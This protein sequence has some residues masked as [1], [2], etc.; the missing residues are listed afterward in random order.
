MTKS[1]AIDPAMAFAGS[2]AGSRAGFGA[3][4]GA[5]S[6]IGEGLLK[7][8]AITQRFSADPP[9]PNQPPAQASV[10]TPASGPVPAPGRRTMTA[11]YLA[12]RKVL[13]EGG[14][15]SE[16]AVERHAA[17]LVAT[18]PRTEP[19]VRAAQIRAQAQLIREGIPWQEN[20]GS[21]FQ[22]PL[23]AF[24]VASGAGTGDLVAWRD[25]AEAAF[26]AAGITTSDPYT[27]VSAI[28]LGTHPRGT[29]FERTAIRLAG[30]RQQALHS[31]YRFS[32][33]PLIV[34]FLMLHVDDTT[35]AERF[36]QQ[37][38][39]W[40][41]ALKERGIK[42]WPERLA[43]ALILMLM[44][45]EAR[46]DR[47]RDVEAWTRALK[48]RRSR[49]RPPSLLTLSGLVLS[50][51]DPEPEVLDALAGATALLWDLAPGI[52]GYTAMDAALLLL[53]LSGQGDDDNH[54]GRI[55]RATLTKIRRTVAM[56][57]AL[58]AIADPKDTGS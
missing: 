12:L 30:A 53:V 37:A 48:S 56:T 49:G 5:G 33:Q 1:A 36:R 41:A 50:G 15:G 4:S 35:P 19:R 38:S 21:R 28:I 22:L 3:D 58:A 43:A 2:G 9:P 54:G 55:D 26:K 34:P 17:A 52:R 18:D 46:D 7:G 10:N 51:I 47:I 39:R 29:G 20:L 27:I 31:T 45:D 44:G 25:E 57:A 32:S 6:A 8:R 23:A 16:G 14:T 42:P 11:H 40:A 24:L 13:D